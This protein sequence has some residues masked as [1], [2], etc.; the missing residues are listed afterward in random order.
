MRGVKTNILPGTKFGLLTVIGGPIFLDHRAHYECK[1][2]CGGRK[3]PRSDA[4]LDGSA[5]S[6]GCSRVDHGAW[7]GGHRTPEYTAWSSM[8][9]RCTNPANKRY[10]QYG[11]RGIQVC[12]R[13][14]LFRNFLI[15]LGERPSNKH[16]LDRIDNDRGYEIGNCRWATPQEQQGNKRTTTKVT[17]CG[18]TLHVAAWARRIGI[19]DAGFCYRL[20]SRWPEE[21]LLRP[22]NRGN[23]P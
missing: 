12:A 2:D 10:A 14:R 22:S 21:A 13:W 17:I 9:S 7:R 18:V 5:Q 23:R 19:S 4:L 20:K 6:C 1:C 11:G 16:S 15:D 3:Q 8:V